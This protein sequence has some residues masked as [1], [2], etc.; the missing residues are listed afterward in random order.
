MKF[1]ACMICALLLTSCDN[2]EDPVD[3]CRD[4]NACQAEGACT[5]S[6]E[7]GKCV[8]TSDADCEASEACRWRGVCAY[9]GEFQ[10]EVFK[11][12]PLGNGSEGYNSCR[13]SEVCKKYNCC[14]PT[15]IFGKNICLNTSAAIPAKC[16]GL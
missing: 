16:L 8:A 2:S 6:T 10:C 14:E 7:T 4:S 12:M 13:N 9:L 15:P 11:S 3:N 1:E 5:L